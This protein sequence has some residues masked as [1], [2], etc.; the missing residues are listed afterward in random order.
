MRAF[1]A[2]VEH[3]YGD[4][5]EAAAAAV[6]SVGGDV[7]RAET[8]SA[9]PDTSQQA[10]LAAVRQSDAVVLVMGTAYGAR[11]SSGLSATHEEWQRL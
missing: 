3:G 10:C 4:R 2:S 8:L 7:V 5:R 9:R 1:I 6:R 11:Q